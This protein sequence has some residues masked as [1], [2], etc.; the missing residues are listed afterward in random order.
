MF[1]FMN[2]NYPSG[3]FDFLIS[4][5]NIP[6]EGQILTLFNENLVVSEVFF[7]FAASKPDKW[8]QTPQKRAADNEESHIRDHG[9]SSSHADRVCED[10]WYISCLFVADSKL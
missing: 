3:V 7:Y 10:D 4:I 6:F 5:P 1:V 8:C 2:P 9:T